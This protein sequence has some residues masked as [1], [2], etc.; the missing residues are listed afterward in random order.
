MPR[1]RKRVAKHYVWSGGRFGHRPLARSDPTSSLSGAG[2]SVGCTRPSDHATERWPKRPPLHKQSILARIAVARIVGVRPSLFENRTK[3]LPGVARTE[4]RRPGPTRCENRRCGPSRRCDL[5]L[6]TEVAGR[7]PTA[8][9][10]FPGAG[11]IRA[12]WPC[13]SRRRGWRHRG[14]SGGPWYRLRGW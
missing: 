13:S 6:A 9:F 1:R 3:T 5:R 2:T 12:G 10:F 8:S 11:G 7:L 14:R 4:Y